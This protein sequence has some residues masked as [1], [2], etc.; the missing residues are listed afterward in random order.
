MNEHARLP[1]GDTQDA[2]SAH[3][4]EVIDG[5]KG[6]ITMEKVSPFLLLCGIGISRIY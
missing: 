6:K 2:C 3:T 4:E 5:E 1:G